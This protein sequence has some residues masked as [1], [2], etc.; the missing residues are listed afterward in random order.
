MAS[1]T[2]KGKD[3][4][5]QSP[6][7]DMNPP[8]PMVVSRVTSWSSDDDTHTQSR[9]W[10]SVGYDAKPDLAARRVRFVPR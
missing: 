7:L 10:S 2:G 3:R 6:A 5:D 1:R 9:S 8:V 4:F